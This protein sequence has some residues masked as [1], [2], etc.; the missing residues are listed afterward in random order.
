MLFVC[1]CVCVCMCVCVCVCVCQHVCVFVTA[2]S[3]SQYAHACLCCLCCLPVCLSV[4]SVYLIMHDVQNR[5]FGPLLHSAS[6]AKAAG[7][8]QAPPGLVSVVDKG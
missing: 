1:V 3:S 2:L 4:L 8:Q 7:L 6:S 5:I